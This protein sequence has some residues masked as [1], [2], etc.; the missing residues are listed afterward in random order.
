M[1]TCASSVAVRTRK[2]YANPLV[3]SQETG[4]YSIE[5]GLTGVGDPRKGG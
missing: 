4:A 1:R 2:A 5:G 3:N